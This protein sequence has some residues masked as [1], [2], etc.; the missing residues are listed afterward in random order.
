MLVPMKAILDAAHRGRYGV[1]ALPGFNEIQIRAAIEAAS[2]AR[3]PLVLLTSNGGDPVFTHGIAKYFADKS[4]VSVALCLDHS[5]S[6]DDCVA[7][8]RTGVTAIM[9]DRSKL[10]YDRNAEEVRELA[11]IARAAGVSVEAELGHVGSGMNYAVDGINALTEPG[12][13]AAFIEETGI[14]ALAVAVGTAHGV[15]SGTP[16]I[17]FARLAEIDAACGKPLVLHGG[18]GSG[19][20]NISKACTMGIAKVNIV[21]D[22]L[23]SAYRASTAGDYSGNGIHRFFP[24]IFKAIRESAL[25]A[26][27]VTGSVG[28]MVYSGRGGGG[29]SGAASSLVEV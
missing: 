5:P 25:R 2:E 10:P 29:A 27:E 14:D 13:A 17:D 26:F 28:K 7:G 12:P 18:S 23:A 1:P 11:K 9:V 6:F 4:D 22:V 16:H 15:Y 24:A 3:S 20:A 8:I 21:T 19:D